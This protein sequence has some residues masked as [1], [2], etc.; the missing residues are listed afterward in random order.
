VAESIQA[1]EGPLRRLDVAAG[2]RDAPRSVG[3]AASL[4]ADKNV[5]AAKCT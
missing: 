5:I 3:A 1:G 2:C 4:M